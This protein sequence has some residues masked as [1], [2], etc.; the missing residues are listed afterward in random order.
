[1]TTTIDLQN[2]NSPDFYTSIHACAAAS[3]RRKTQTNTRYKNFRQTHFTAGD[4]EQFQQRRNATNGDICMKEIDISKNLYVDQPFE[5]WDKYTDIPATAVIDTFRYIFNKFKK[6]IFVKIKGGKVVVFLPFSKARFTNE[7][8]SEI[9]IDPKFKSLDAFLQSITGKGY[10]YNN[11]T[12]NH[13]MSEWYANNCIVRY[14][15]SYASQLPNE[16]DT[17]VG[18]VKHMLEELCANREIPD[19]E[20]FMNR[21][22]FPILTRNGTEP[23]NGIWGN[24]KPLVSH[25]YEKYIPVLSMCKTNNYADILSPTHE[26]WARVQSKKGRW[27]PRSC[28]NYNDSFDTPWDDKK[29]TAVF[30]GASTGCGVTIA[31]N[32][33]LNL[34]YISNTTTTKEGEAPLLDAGITKWNTR[35]RKL[36]TSPYLQSIDIS[37]IGINLV[38]SLTR[39]EQSSYNI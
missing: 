34:A 35:P 29:P 3:R 25:N 36:S 1:M 31:T 38:P 21:R 37:N 5:V 11:K 10:R 39:I 30:R 14:D 18:T 8:S 20:F 24:N 13:N 22:D 4:E 16:G 23:Y 2:R 6:G 12:V 33:R 15:V 19:I 26:D 32:P 27:F 17:N 7:W 9:S 28:G